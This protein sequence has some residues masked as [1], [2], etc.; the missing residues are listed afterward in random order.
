M[1]S[2][3]IAQ[4]VQQRAA[5]LLGQN[6]QE[7]IDP[8]FVRQC[9]D[10][11][12]RGDGCLYATINRG[13]CLY[14]ATPKDGEWYFWDGHVW[15][16]DVF[17]RTKDAIE[18]CALEYK[19]EA[20]ALALEILKEEI[21]KKHDDAWKLDLK[22]KWDSRVNRLRSS[23]GAARVLE[24]APVVD[25]SMACRE[26]DFDKKPWLLP[27]RNGVIDLRTGA[28]TSGRPE[29]KLTRTLDIDYDPRADYAP[30][31]KIVEEIA[32]SKDVAAF[33]KRTFGYAITGL[34]HEQYIWIFTGP[35]RNGKGI[36]FNLIGEVMGPYYHEINRA[37]ILEQRNEPGPAA[38]SEHKYSLLGKRIIVGAETNRGQK[39]DASAIKSLT[40]EDKITCRPLFSAEISFDPSH[41]LFLHTNHIP[42]GLTKDFALLQRLLKIE[43]PFMYVDDIELEKKKKPGHAA[44][45]R[46]KDPKLKEKLR[47]IKPGI[48]RW[49]VEGCREWQEIGLSPP[50]EILDGV[51]ALANEE[52][53]IGQF[54]GDCLVLHPDEPDL[55]IGC[56]SMYEAF[57]WW[58]S[59]NMDAREQRIPAMKTINGAI[60]E[61]GYKVEKIGGKTW[62][63]AHTINPDI[64]KEV[65]EYTAKHGHKS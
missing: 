15:E 42:I 30:W 9:L 34:S 52:D 8:D 11:N 26:S 24:W 31:E 5:D 60:R 20:D 13:K 2:E 37:M 12:E 25:T 64:V 29:D 36:L 51:S 44:R 38:A 61:R 55:R 39:I 43:F 63:L 19:K 46:Q 35:G 33:I 41:T 28:L 18:L 16:A 45:F 6:E 57:K 48:L 65:G 56:T 1:S 27:V 58:W 7:P 62:I 47:E 49:L 23:A 14:N 59:E 3:D 4:Q 53:Y 54:I 17:K 10:S 21:D 50:K 32:D 40:G 22:K